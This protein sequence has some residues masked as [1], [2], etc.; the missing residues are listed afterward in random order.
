MLILTSGLCGMTLAQP[1]LA[2]SSRGAN[3]EARF[4]AAQRSVENQLIVEEIE[5]AGFEI[6]VVEGFDEEWEEDIWVESEADDLDANFTDPTETARFDM[7]DVPQPDEIA[8]GWSDVA[9]ENPDL[10][11]EEHDQSITNVED[12][13][14][15]YG[16]MRGEDEAADDQE[17]LIENEVAVDEDLSWDE[18]SDLSE[19]ESN[20]W[21]E[22]S[23][24]W[25]AVMDDLDEFDSDLDGEEDLDLL[26]EMYNTN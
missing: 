4:E 19:T 15:E 26:E 20:W 25:M 6:D 17:L 11:A 12:G 5:D 14:Q 21:E 24:Q 16:T 3:E 8:D 7:G 10:V 2:S 18:E 1:G 22:P 13:N 23:E 9:W